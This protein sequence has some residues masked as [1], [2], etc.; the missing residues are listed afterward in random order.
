MKKSTVKLIEAKFKKDFDNLSYEIRK[1][2]RD[3]TR[4][5]K[6]QKELKELRKG[7]F[8]L[9]SYVRGYK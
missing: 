5:A 6:K 4:L 9:L 1:N 2:K 3:I 8:D 7:L